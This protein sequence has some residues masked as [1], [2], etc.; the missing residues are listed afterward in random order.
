MNYRIE[1]D[2]MGEVQV[3]SDKYWGAQTQRSKENFRI[4]DGRMPLEIIK[5]FGYLK[6]AAAATN[7]ELGVLPKEKADLI[8]QVCD[9][10]I[11]GKLDDRGVSG[12]LRTDIG[13]FRAEARWL[14]ALSYWHAMDHFGNVPFVTEQDAVGAF[15]PKQINRADLFTY[16]EDEL[17]TIEPLMVDA[18][19]N[20][21]ARADKAA[22]WMLLAKL[23]IRQKIPII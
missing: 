21:Y 19:A 8:M 10:I 14:R 22:V 4:G 12:Q 17:K 2:T 13:Y 11:E 18:R 3:P 20:E 15:F 6:K 5:G 16:I 1:K 7:L 23:Y 9:E